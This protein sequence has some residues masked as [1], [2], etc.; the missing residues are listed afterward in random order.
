MGFNDFIKTVAEW[1]RLDGIN[2]RT[3]QS[4]R[5]RLDVG[6]RFGRGYAITQN[7]WKAIKASLVGSGNWERTKL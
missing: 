6:T 3:A 2:V 4:A 1:A 5:Q 7:Q